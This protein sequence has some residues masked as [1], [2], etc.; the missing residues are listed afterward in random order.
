MRSIWT[1]TRQWPVRIFK[2][3]CIYGIE[4]VRSGLSDQV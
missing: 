4:A 2:C 1:T 3:V